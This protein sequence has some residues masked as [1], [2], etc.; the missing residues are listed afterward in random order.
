MLS[1]LRATFDRE[2]TTRKCRD[3][4]CD[5]TSCRNTR[6]CGTCDPNERRSLRAA[7]NYGRR[8]ARCTII[9]FDSIEQAASLELDHIYGRDQNHAVNGQ[10]VVCWRNN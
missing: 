8:C 7:R 1:R 3:C 9:I 2:M 10:C 5:F 4:G 6:F